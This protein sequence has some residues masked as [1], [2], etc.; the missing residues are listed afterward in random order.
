MLNIIFSRANGKYVIDLILIFIFY[1]LS[2]YN[3]GS[4]KHELIEN[5]TLVDLNTVACKLLSRLV[6]VI[7]FFF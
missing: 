5:G 4:I 2:I 1:F 3:I 6:N 7:Q